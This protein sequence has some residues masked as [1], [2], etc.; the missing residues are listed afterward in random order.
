M[1]V[2]AHYLGYILVVLGRI[3]ADLTSWSTYGNGVDTVAERTESVCIFEAV[4]KNEHRESTVLQG[5][6]EMTDRSAHVVD[7]VNMPRA[8]F[9]TE[10]GAR[11]DRY[12]HFC[13]HGSASG[14]YVGSRSTLVG[15]EHFP[16]GSGAA[17]RFMTVSACGEPGID[18][19]ERF[20]A[21]LGLAAIVAPMGT[22]YFPEAAVFYSAFYAALF[23]MRNPSKRSRDESLVRF[24]D[25]FQRA[26]CAYLGLG[27]FGAFR[28]LYWLHD[29]RHEVL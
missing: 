19:W 29:G 7:A 5:L 11:K 4:P 2:S 17:D 22:V 16:E 10:V 13:S 3:C 8:A 24:I 18:V 14:L 27:G 21:K 15:P 25:A 9:V 20:H 1:L 6:I 12:L 26:R 28:L 23:G